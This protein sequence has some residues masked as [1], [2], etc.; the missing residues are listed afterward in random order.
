MQPNLAK[1]DQDSGLD[2]SVVERKDQPGVWTV[3][4]IDIA[5]DGDIYQALFIGRDARERA[6][7]Y[8]QFKYGRQ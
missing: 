5:G 3:E 1:K 7:E 6:S 2:V 4:A 8:A